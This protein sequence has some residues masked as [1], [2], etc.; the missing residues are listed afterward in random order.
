MP[1][2]NEPSVTDTADR[3]T[4]AARREEAFGASVPA[5]IA[6]TKRRIATVTL[7]P[8]TKF[9]R[10]VPRDELCEAEVAEL[11]ERVTDATVAR[12]AE[13]DDDP[14]R[15]AATER[16]M[17]ATTPDVAASVA[18]FAFRVDVPAS[19]AREA[20]SRRAEDLL[21]VARAEVAADRLAEGDTDFAAITAVAAWKLR[22]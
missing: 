11:A 2:P 5:R 7:A 3:D 15:L 1:R 19:G 6:D 9:R 17:A 12:V 10:I 22:R 21:T 18:S 20:A 14:R 16:A 8:A 4:A 13:G